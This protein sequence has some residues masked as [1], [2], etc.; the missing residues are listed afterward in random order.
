[1]SFRLIYRLHAN[2]I[3]KTLSR[4]GV[5]GWQKATDTQVAADAGLAA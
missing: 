3:R 4:Q 2:D 1:M 5:C